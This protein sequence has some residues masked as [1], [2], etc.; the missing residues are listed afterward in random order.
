MALKISSSEREVEMR[1]V[2]IQ[3]ANIAPEIINKGQKL[4]G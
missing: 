1:P 3:Q 2:L 4:N